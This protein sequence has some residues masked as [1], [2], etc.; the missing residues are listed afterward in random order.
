MKQIDLKTLKEVIDFL[1]DDTIIFLANKDEVNDQSIEEHK[2]QESNFLL[3]PKT[4]NISDT[5]LMDWRP[6]YYFRPCSSNDK[7]STIIDEIAYWLSDN[8]ITDKIINNT[9]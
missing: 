6:S 5:N 7:E 2:N 4:K 8:D 1:D 3:K 9:R